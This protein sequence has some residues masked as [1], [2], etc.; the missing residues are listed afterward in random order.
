MI[1]NC[2][3]FCIFYGRTFWMNGCKRGFLREYDTPWNLMKL[4]D[5]FFL[6]TMFWYVSFFKFFTFLFSSIPWMCSGGLEWVNW[7]HCFRLLFG[8]GHFAWMLEWSFDCSSQ[9]RF[10]KLSSSKQRK[11]FLFR[12]LTF[13]L[14]K[15]DWF[16]LMLFECTYV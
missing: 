15:C 10:V 9:F 4:L 6:G 11:V 1:G 14:R 8:F 7:I 16:L 13:F 12:N 3:W 5:L 2:T